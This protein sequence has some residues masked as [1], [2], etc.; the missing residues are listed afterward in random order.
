MEYRIDIQQNKIS[1][2]FYAQP[3]IQIFKTFL[4]LS[5]TLKDLLSEKKIN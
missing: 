4:P 2:H 3:Y 1:Q 5:W